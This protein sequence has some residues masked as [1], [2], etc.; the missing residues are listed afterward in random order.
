M[1]LSR[2]P[3]TI[4]VRHTVTIRVARTSCNLPCDLHDGL[5]Q[6][7][8]R[9]VSAAPHLGCLFALFRTKFASSRNP[10]S[11]TR[12]ERSWATP[13]PFCGRRC[14]RTIRR[15]QAIHLPPAKRTQQPPKMGLR[16]GN[17]PLA[18]FLVVS[19]RVPTVCRSQGCS[20]PPRHVPPEKEAAYYAISCTGGGGNQLGSRPVFFLW[21]RYN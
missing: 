5:G 1:R 12:C 16:W 8:G 18:V 20:D 6:R 7:R 17:D 13:V 2:A 10:R 4:G 3:S 9:A 21:R 11:R 14:Y 19:P 15:A